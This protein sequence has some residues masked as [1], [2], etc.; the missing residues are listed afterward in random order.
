MSSFITQMRTLSSIKASIKFNS[1]SF[2]L[3]WIIM[4]VSRDKN[5]YYSSNPTLLLLNREQREVIKQKSKTEEKKDNKDGIQHPTWPTYG[6]NIRQTPPPLSKITN[7]YWSWGQI[8]MSMW[9]FLT[10]SASGRGTWSYLE[11]PHI[12]HK[13]ASVIDIRIDWIPTHRTL[14]RKWF[15]AYICSQVRDLHILF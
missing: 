3:Q 2:I 15:V 4:R 5:P 12:A 11:V 7:P 9:R 1:K 10:Y 6:Q 13:S 14:I 8:G